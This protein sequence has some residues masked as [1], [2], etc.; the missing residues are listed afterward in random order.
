MKSEIVK[1]TRL[2]IGKLI[3]YIFVLLRLKNMDI[4]ERSKKVKRYSKLVELTE[5]ILVQFEDFCKKNDK[6][7]E[8]DPA[9]DVYD[10]ALKYL[11]SKSDEWV[12]FKYLDS[13]FRIVIDY[14]SNFTEVMIRTYALLPR[15]TDNSK[16]KNVL[17]ESMDI[18]GNQ[19]Q[20][21][22][23]GTNSHLKEKIECFSIEYIDYLWAKVIGQS[24]N[25]SLNYAGLGEN[26]EK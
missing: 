14:N 9:H 7:P 1:K 24:R 26:R 16:Y 15:D 22:L 23:K 5:P 6:Y 8:N 11:R 13:R 2:R 3:S 18:Y 10:V 12:E 4:H 20:G 17:L 21:F 25:D 19:T